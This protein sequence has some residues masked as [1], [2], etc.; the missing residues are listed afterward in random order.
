MSQN[1]HLYKSIM[2][3]LELVHQ[4][5]IFTA[6]NKFQ[7]CLL[8][9]PGPNLSMQFQ[10]TLN[11]DNDSPV[12]HRPPPHCPMHFFLE[13]SLDSQSWAITD[14]GHRWLTDTTGNIRAFFF[15]TRLLHL[16]WHYQLNLSF[17]MMTTVHFEIGCDHSVPSC[18]LSQHTLE[19]VPTT[20]HMMKAFYFTQRD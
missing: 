11:E 20:W 12:V 1:I 14:R 17:S 5:Y 18:H 10:Y 19:Y 7:L 8:N 6:H 15:S 16:M 9:C 2:N 13:Q 3:G 4:L